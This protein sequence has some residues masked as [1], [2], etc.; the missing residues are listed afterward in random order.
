ML[1]YL[2]LALKYTNTYPHI[3][4]ITFTNKAANEIKQRILDTLH[5]IALSVPGQIKGKT[6]DIVKDLCQNTGLDEANI[7]TNAGTV[8]SSVLHHYSDF[9]VSTID[10]FMH[11]IIRSFAFDLKLSLSFE[12]ELDTESLIN[13]AVDE[14]ISKT[15]KDTELTDIL[16][17]YVVRQAENDEN[18]DIRDDLRKTAAALFKEKM[19]GLIP[20]LEKRSFTGEDFKKIHTSCSLMKNEIKAQGK[21]A[22]ALISSLGFSPEDF[23]YGVNGVCSFF[24]KAAD[25][26]YAEYG[27]R[28]RN[29][30]EL[31]IWFKKG[32]Q[33][34]NNLAGNEDKL[35]SVILKVC[36]IQ[37][38]LRFF[39]I[40]RNNFHAT[41]LMKKISDELEF[42]RKQR[43]IVPISDFNTLISN[44]VR[45]QPVPFIYLRAGEK[46]RHFMID[47]FQDTSEMQWENF[48]PLIENS[49]SDSKLSMI[50]GDGKQAIYRFKNGDAEQFVKLPALRN[51]HL[52]PY[53][54]GRENLL[55][56]QYQA[57]NLSR[58]YRS[59]KE[60]VTFNNDFFLFAAPVFVPEYAHY[61][62]KNEV[63]QSFK[64][65]NEGGM[66]N[67]DFVS[68]ENIIPRILDLVNKIVHEGY[69]YGDIAILTRVNKDAINIASQ[70]QNAGIRVVSSES[71]LLSSSA[72]VNFLLHWIR[73]IANHDDRTAIQGIIQYLVQYKKGCSLIEKTILPDWNYLNALLNELSIEIEPASFDNLSF[74][75]T[76][77][78]LIRKFDLYISNPL[79]IRF[80]LDEILKFMQRKSSG[81]TGFLEHWEQN[82]EKLSVSVPKSKEA[83]QILTVHKS[84]GL[85]FPVVIYAY[86]DQKK[87]I[88]DLT[89]SNLK[90][91]LPFNDN[92]E[93]LDIPLVFRY[94]PEHKG[95]P[96]EEE[97]LLEKAKM[98]LDKFN[99]Y[100][101]AFTRASERL[102]LVLEEV[103]KPLSNPAKLNELVKYYIDQKNKP[104]LSGNGKKITGWYSDEMDNESSVSSGINT[105]YETAD[106]RKKLIISKRSPSD[107]GLSGDE[108]DSNNGLRP[109]EKKMSRIEYGKLVHSIL[110]QA[111]SIEGLITAIE[112]ALNV[113]ES[114]DGELKSQLLAVA[115]KIARLPETHWLFGE[116]TVLC[117]NEIIT[118]GGKTYRPDRVILADKITYIV[119]F[120]T[121][122]P[123][124]KHEEQLLLY[125]DLIRKMGYPDPNGYLIYL[126][127][128]VRA[129]KISKTE[130]LLA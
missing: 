38:E 128:E 72:E 45:E 32:S 61:Y 90:V 64:E 74:Y 62:P 54:K 123:D 49:L 41:L 14:L 82:S 116:G 130:A 3:L 44:V 104:L 4:A 12:V 60:I 110:S 56:S 94:S 83:V 91:K 92:H 33:L 112:R 77:E 2:S 29:A 99:L 115:D 11:R 95:T 37:E 15:G 13:T 68:A 39:E 5:E 93:E 120:K 31:N 47:E 58:N 125:M 10:S 20:A 55:R 127:D 40:I 126:G 101:V 85:D 102:Y 1:G 79:Y 9:A 28:V 111:L 59:R 84:K 117:E 124:E 108:A 22:L 26:I 66:V 17:N 107:W 21:S 57:E 114:E 27:E 67:I 121:G 118:T 51:S 30:V 36:E 25:G 73:L 81:A 43:N 50:V 48:L 53:L 76:V 100:Y 88:Y 89:W 106:W 109:D 6:K 46:F 71:L 18:W 69:K 105:I 119:D 129:V 96:L 70:L 98:N 86:P 24:R 16:K 97:F 34:Y 65:N 63:E 23:A 80:F 87:D 103:T 113:A 8:L 42:I 52:Y 19:L 122:M 75:D 7:I 35:T 78:Y